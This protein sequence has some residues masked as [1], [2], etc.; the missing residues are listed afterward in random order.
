M[1]KIF[2]DKSNKT[3]HT[4]DHTNGQAKPVVDIRRTQK[5][6]DTAVSDTRKLSEN[7]ISTSD[8]FAPIAAQ[9]CPNVTTSCSHVPVH[10]FSLVNNCY[11]Q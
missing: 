6:W 8:L 1:L 5:E 7:E 11:H 2:N 9:I 10:W 4:K 3:Y